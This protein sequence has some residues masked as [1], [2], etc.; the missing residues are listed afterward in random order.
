MTRSTTT[1]SEFPVVGRQAAPEQPF[2]LLV[3]MLRKA[4]AISQAH[5][6]ETSAETYSGVGSEEMNIDLIL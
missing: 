4:A 2:G 1:W 6:K 5:L 3:W